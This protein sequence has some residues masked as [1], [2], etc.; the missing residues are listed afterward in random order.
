M[1]QGAIQ[2]VQCCELAPEVNVLVQSGPCSTGLLGLL[3]TWAEQVTRGSDRVGPLWP[4]TCFGAR[5]GSGRPSREQCGGREGAGGSISQAGRRFN[6]PQVLTT[7][8]AASWL[9]TTLR[10]LREACLVKLG[11][12][13]F[14]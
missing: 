11:G 6:P 4:G 14:L 2:G 9:P 10:A 8:G 3:E 12:G 1:I 13:N 7:S 5:S